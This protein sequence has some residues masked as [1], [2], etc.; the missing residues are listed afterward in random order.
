[1]SEAKKGNKLNVGRVRNDMVER[2]SK[3]ITMFSAK[4][5]VIKHFE[6]SVLAVRELGIHRATISACLKGKVRTAKANDGKVY[7]FMEGVVTEVLAP[8]KHRQHKGLGEVLQL[9]TEQ[10]IVAKYR[11]AKEASEV[12]GIFDVSI[13]RCLH[14]KQKLA[15]GFKW[16][17]VNSLEG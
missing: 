7:R 6:S 14:G 8:I 16:Q 5:E 4:G 12:T 3:P 9:T 10:I 11:T 13:R 17:L 1:M 15:G 2:F